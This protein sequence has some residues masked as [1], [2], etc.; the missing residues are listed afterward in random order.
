MEHAKPAE[1]CDGVA[2]SIMDFF[3][4][5]T[6]YKV[7]GILFDPENPWDKNPTPGR[8]SP[9]HFA[10]LKG[11]SLAVQSLL[12]KG[13]EV[14]AQG[15]EYGNALQAASAGGHQDIVKLLL[16]KGA[17]VNAQGG[18]YGNALQAA[19]EGGVNAQ[20]GFYGNALQAASF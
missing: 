20:G 19:S 5:P 4:S 16:D 13:A 10:S 9:L 15:G 3:Q 12:E 1:T 11:L 6:T 8:A 17:D 14:N 2:K 7:W 18:E